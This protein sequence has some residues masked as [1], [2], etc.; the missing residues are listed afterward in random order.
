[1]STVWKKPQD[2]RSEVDTSGSDIKLGGPAASEAPI[3][4]AYPA[5]GPLDM[6]ALYEDIVR[7]FPITIKRLGE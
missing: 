6:K 1:M 3:R 2:A 5:S 7:R 4:K